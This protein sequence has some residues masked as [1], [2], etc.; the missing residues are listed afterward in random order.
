[1]LQCLCADN[2]R[3]GL[4]QGKTRRLDS[5]ESQ[6]A[7]GE[8]NAAQSP[9]LKMVDKSLSHPAEFT[10]LPHV[11]RELNLCGFQG[12]HNTVQCS[13]LLQSSPRVSFV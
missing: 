1:M 13:A 3:E 2:L 5:K 6:V 12:E 7:F 10:F 4:C 8:I 11:H 9:F